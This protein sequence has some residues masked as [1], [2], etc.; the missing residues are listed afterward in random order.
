MIFVSGFDA[1]ITTNV[2]RSSAM[3]RA[4]RAGREGKG[5]C[6]RLYTQE[7]F[8]DMEYSPQ[9]E[10][11]RTNLTSAILQLKCVGQDLENM[12]FMDRPHPESGT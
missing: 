6:F 1:L 3:Q 11:Q 10:I 5:Y 7:A 2:T 4:G 8:E 9:P 12:E